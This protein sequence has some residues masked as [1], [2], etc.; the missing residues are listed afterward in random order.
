M[1]FGR[2]FFSDTF[3]S[4]QPVQACFVAAWH[5]KHARQCPNGET[6]KKDWGCL[7]LV[8][9]LFLLAWQCFFSTFF[10]TFL[11]FF[12][13]LISQMLSLL[14][15]RRCWKRQVVLKPWWKTAPNFWWPW[16]CP[17]SSR[18]RHWRHRRR[19]MRPR[20]PRP[21]RRWSTQRC[22]HGCR[23]KTTPATPGRCWRSVLNCGEH[24]K[25]RRS[26]IHSCKPKW[27][28]DFGIDSIW[29]GIW[30]HFCLCWHLAGWKSFF[31][32]DVGPPWNL[33]SRAVASIPKDRHHL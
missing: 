19:S 18:L 29:C 33:T 16:P 26:W 30:W 32:L 17:K 4:L 28:L 10:L 15:D 13:H 3:Q 20:R 5:S 31:F 2:H 22:C 9:L 12:W 11:P 23:W 6:I 27:H 1:K 24:G 25:G 7:A 21:W 14:A 8:L